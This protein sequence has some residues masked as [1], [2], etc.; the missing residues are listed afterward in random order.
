MHKPL[1][2]H[3]KGTIVSTTL[4]SEYLGG[5]LLRWEHGWDHHLPGRGIDDTYA[6]DFHISTVKKR[7]ENSCNH[8]QRSQDFEPAVCVKIS[9]TLAKWNFPPTIIFPLGASFDSKQPRGVQN[10]EEKTYRGE[11]EQ[12]TKLCLHIYIF[13]TL[14]F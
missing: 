3:K 4:S 6:S 5:R 13:I 14:N 1:R 12:L 8:D 10:E 11:C 9:V 2:Y 7:E